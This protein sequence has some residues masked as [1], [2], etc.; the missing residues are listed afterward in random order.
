MDMTKLLPC[1]FCGGEA[2]RVDNGPTAHQAQIARSWGDDVYDGGSFIRCTACDAATTIHYERRENLTSDWNRRVHYKR[3]ALAKNL[4]KLDNVILRDIWST[5][6]PEEDAN[7][8]RT[9][10]AKADDLLS[11]MSLDLEYG[12]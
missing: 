1:P 2:E 6:G 7:N 11:F 12:A 10:L 5:V 3:E 9:Y 8:W 4:A